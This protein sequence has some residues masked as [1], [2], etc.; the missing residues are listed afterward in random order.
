LY[1]PFGPPVIA[2]VARR[3]AAHS[4]EHGCR[5]V[6]IYVDPRHRAVF[7]ETGQFGILEETPQALIMATPRAPATAAA[8]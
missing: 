3:L 8:G 4:E 5:V 1:N 6:V 2:A 7:E